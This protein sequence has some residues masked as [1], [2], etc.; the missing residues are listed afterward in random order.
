MSR[1]GAGGW[2]ADVDATYVDLLTL[3]S[4][5]DFVARRPSLK[6][7]VVTSFDQDVVELAEAGW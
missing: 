7:A 4:P 3:M 2:L 6:Q 1:G 5:A